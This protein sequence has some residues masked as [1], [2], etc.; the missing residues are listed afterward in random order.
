MVADRSDT[1]QSERSSGGSV[2]TSTAAGAA[3]TVV[4][5]MESLTGTVRLSTCP[6]AAG[7]VVEVAPIVH[8]RNIFN[9]RP[10]SWIDSIRFLTS[11]E[12]KTRPGLP[13]DARW[14]IS[15]TRLTL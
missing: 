13:V 7:A 8:E 10:S 3:T 6:V 11:V 9:V 12:V 4:S 2:F 1:H 5:S 14:S 15:S